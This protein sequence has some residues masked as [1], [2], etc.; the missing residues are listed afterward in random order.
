MKLYKLLVLSLSL[1]TFNISAD[2]FEIGKKKAQVC[3]TCHGT[4]GIAS[5]PTYPNLQGQH[6]EYLVEALKAY[7]EKRRTGGFAMLMQPQADA[8][9][10]QDMK[11]IAHYFSNIK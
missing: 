3:M 2:Q 7:K 8:L 1:F 10:E 5:I 9:T 4:E 11:D 6:S